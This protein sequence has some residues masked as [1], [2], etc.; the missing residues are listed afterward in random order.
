M[1]NPSRQFPSTS[2]NGSLVDEQSRFWL[3]NS[4]PASPTKAPTNAVPYFDLYAPAKPM[5]GTGQRDSHLLQQ[6]SRRHSVTASAGSPVLSSHKLYSRNN[7]DAVFVDLDDTDTS[8]NS[9]ASPTI[10]RKIGRSRSDPIAPV[11][12]QSP[13]PQSGTIQASRYK[14][15]LCNTFVENGKCRYGEKCQFAHG[16]DELRSIARHPKYRTEKCRSFH[17]TGS[18]SYG[19]RCHF[20]HLEPHGQLSSSSSSHHDY[21]SVPLTAPAASGNAIISQPPGSKFVHNPAAAALALQQAAG[22]GRPRAVSLSAFSHPIPI[23]NGFIADHHAELGSCSDSRTTSI[24]SGSFP[25]T[26]LSLSPGVDGHC[27]SWF[28]AHQD[29]PLGSLSGI[30]G[31]GSV[32]EECGDVPGPWTVALSCINILDLED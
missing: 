19:Q 32:T 20:I 11:A 5:P 26:P 16:L 12:L 21:P 1:G 28:T 4:V 9:T 25:S 14:T 3:P 6:Q 18:C 17:T 7:Y 31:L 15:E 30:D 8:S 23:A 27:H 29:F 13:V 24:S 2:S 22:A 10:H